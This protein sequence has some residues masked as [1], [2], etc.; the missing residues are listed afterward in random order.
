MKKRLEKRNMKRLF[1]VL[2]IFSLFISGS[3]TALAEADDGENLKGEAALAYYSDHLDD[4]DIDAY[5]KIGTLYR[6]GLDG[7]PRNYQT[8]I[9]W[10]QKGIDAGKVPSITGLGYMYLHGFGIVRDYEKALELFR[11][12][13]EQDD[14][15][16]MSLI[17]TMYELGLSVE[18]ND[19]TALEWYRKASNAGYDFARVKLGEYAIYVEGDTEKGLELYQKAADD[20]ILEAY[21]FLGDYYALKEGDAAA[22]PYYMQGAE[23]GEKNC[24]GKVG[25]MYSYGYGVQSSY[26]QAVDWLTRGSERGDL[27][28]MCVLADKYFIGEFGISKP[29]RAKTLYTEAAARG[30]AYAL[31]T[32]AYRMDAKPTTGYDQTKDETTRALELYGKALVCFRDEQNKVKNAWHYHTY[33]SWD[34]DKLMEYIDGMV[35]NHVCT[36]EESDAV[37]NEQVENFRLD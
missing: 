11:Q 12:A 1:S 23:L 33:C 15:R 8:A 29:D 32:V 18:K 3:L 37:I 7:I 25:C 20:G 28:S 10:Y 19:E 26:T 16:A 36:R 22:K 34:T 27:P 2:L 5:E 30:E 14:G 31:R 13:A 9:E 21:W 24:L 4:P 35:V 6:E 17:G